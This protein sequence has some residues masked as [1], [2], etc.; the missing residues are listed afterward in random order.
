MKNS[1]RDRFDGRLMTASKAKQDR[2]ERF[3]SAA[4]DPERLAKRARRVE[5]TVT[6]EAERK[7]KA[8]Q[9]RQEKEDLE[10]QQ[11]EDDK[12]ETE[13]A[14]VREAKHEAQLA[15]TA[16][17]IVAQNS[18]RE[19]ERKAERDRRYAARRNRKR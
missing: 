6:R 14:A 10:R 12:R 8:T 18:A 9:L 2:L 19:A 11:S 17:Q 4:G 5:A 1:D 16:D 7:L 15:E 13:Q 3:Q